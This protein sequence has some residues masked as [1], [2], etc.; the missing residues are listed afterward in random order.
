MPS[1]SVRT[2]AEVREYTGDEWIARQSQT[3]EGQAL[4]KSMFGGGDGDSS[5][6]SDRAS[7]RRDT[8]PSG[9]SDSRST[10]STTKAS[11]EHLQSHTRRASDDSA[12]GPD[13]SG[14]SA[15]SSGD[16]ASVTQTEDTVTEDTDH[17]DTTSG[18]STK[19]SG[20]K[21]HSGSGSGKDSGSG[22]GKDSGADSDSS[23][24]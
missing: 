21:K 7:V 11:A 16:S 6:A 14:Q 22:S 20:N 24:D 13:S 5:S 1:G 12:T 10:G 17:S 8:R 23:D 15:L 9:D 3:P 18:E 2:E 19:T 4:M